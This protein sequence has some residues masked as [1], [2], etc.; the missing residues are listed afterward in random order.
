MVEQTTLISA[1][2]AAKDLERDQSGT[3]A[4]KFIAM[5]FLIWGVFVIL[6]NN[7]LKLLLLGR[8]V[9]VPM[10]VILLGAIGGMLLSGVVGLFMGA[11]VLALGAF[12]NELFLA[13]E[14]RDHRVV[15]APN[16][17]RF[18][19]TDVDERKN[20]GQGHHHNNLWLPM[21]C[22]VVYIGIVAI[23]LTVI[24]MSEAA[25]ARYVNGQ[26]VRLDRE[27]SASG[28]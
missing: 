5:L 22:T 13:L 14:A 23:G 26:Y 2:L 19:C 17:E 25:E 20:P 7:V 8:G 10:L 21:R 16:A 28:V 11:I 6:L 3:G 1:N 18:H 24:E 9:D 27:R 15:I 12:A 4:V